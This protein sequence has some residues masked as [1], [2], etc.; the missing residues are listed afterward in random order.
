MNEVV[1]SQNTKQPLILVA[2]ADG[3]SA[4]VLARYLSS[5]GYR[6]AHTSRG[7]EALRLACVERV[8]LAI[9]DVTL[10][11]MSG[12]M[13]AFRLR[14]VEPEVQVLMTAADDRPEIE[15]RARQ[16]GII[17]YAHKPID[18]ELLEAVVAKA[19]EGSGRR[20]GRGIK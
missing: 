12:Q 19:S 15:M 8:G 14:E 17:Y 7:E 13:L 18:L 6:A 9:V 16:V 4:R 3:N 1:H 5:L 20:W 11:D 2:D 10:E